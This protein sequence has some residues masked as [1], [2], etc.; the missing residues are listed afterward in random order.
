LS[1]EERQALRCIG[2]KLLTSAQ[3]QGSVT[4][5]CPDNKAVDLALQQGDQGLVDE[6]APADAV[7]STYAPVI[8]GIRNAVMTSLHLATK[9]SVERRDVE[10]NTALKGASVLAQLGGF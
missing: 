5:S 10:L 4:I 2:A 6:F 7:E 8:V 3:I 1:S 9:G